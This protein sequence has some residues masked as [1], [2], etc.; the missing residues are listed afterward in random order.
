MKAKLILTTLLMVL[1]AKSFAQDIIHTLN[2]PPIEA[3]VTEISDDYVL[4]KTFDNLDGPDYRIPV[5]HVARIV[6]E[7][8]TEKV[9][10]PANAKEAEEE[11]RGPYGPLVYRAG[12]Y[13][14]NLGRLYH[15]Q[16]R[17]CLGESVYNNDYK[18]A[19]SQFQWG[20]GL[21]V[22]GATVL[23]ASIAGGVVYTYINKQ[24][25]KTANPAPFIAAGLVGAA[26]VGG[27]IPLWVSGN[28]K[29]ST[30][31]DDFNQQHDAYGYSPSLQF[32]AT[33]SGIGL[34]L[35]F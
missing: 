15:K 31:A 12:I 2:T 33:G 27:G 34:A 9:F 16:L 10:A 23:L 20:S 1:C 6:F 29:L 11:Y 18:K 4:Y 3:K 7:N 28:R 17:Q 24:L 19:H 22:G 14:D 13:Y 25:E 21:T 30:I 26:C 8:G 35:R 32:G 5:T